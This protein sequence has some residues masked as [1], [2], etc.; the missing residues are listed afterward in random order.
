MSNDD[1]LK[2]DSCEGKRSS[3]QR[4]NYLLKAFKE[5]LDKNFVDFEFSRQR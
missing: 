1:Q 5:D 4:N 3:N 2:N